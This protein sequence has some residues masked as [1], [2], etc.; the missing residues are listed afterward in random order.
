MGFDEKAELSSREAGI[1]KRTEY[2][3]SQEQ[4]EYPAREKHSRYENT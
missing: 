4:P 2:K 1:R 3:K